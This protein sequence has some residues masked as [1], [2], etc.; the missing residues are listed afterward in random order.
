[1]H[2]R[3]TCMTVPPTVTVFTM[4][5]IEFALLNHPAFQPVLRDIITASLSNY[6]KTPNTRR[7][8]DLVM[9]FATYIYI[10]AEK[11]CYEVLFSNL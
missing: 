9:K 1:M 8:S 2:K 10:L 4:D 3:Q 6:N 5:I 7:F 11:Q